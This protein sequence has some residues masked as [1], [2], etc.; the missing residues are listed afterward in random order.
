MISLKH[1]ILH[2]QTWVRCKARYS[3]GE[4]RWLTL[5][6]HEETEGVELGL[7]PSTHP[8]TRAYQD[9]FMAD[10]IPVSAFSAD[11]IETGVAKLKS[12]GVGSTQPPVKAG[13]AAISVFDDTCGTSS[14]SSSCM[15]DRGVAK[16][17]HPGA[18]LLVPPSLTSVSSPNYNSNVSVVGSI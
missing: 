6:S 11:D 12:V 1:M 9:A 10:G 18:V 13:G 15:F 4:Q 16:L 17:R 7:E 2:E 8:A 5:V 3:T 14:S